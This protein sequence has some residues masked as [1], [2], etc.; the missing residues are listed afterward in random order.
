MNTHKGIVLSLALIALISMVT[1]HAFAFGN[2][3]SINEFSH[4]RQGDY[5]QVTIQ[6][7]GPGGVFLYG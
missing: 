5:Y 4:E 7:Q 1:P 3:V 6:V 2:S